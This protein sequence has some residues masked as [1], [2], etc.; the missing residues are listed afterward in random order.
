[1]YVI[2]T[3]DI[4]NDK[5]R[6]K[7]AKNLLQFGIRTQKSVFECEVNKKELVIIKKIASK[8]SDD[9]DLVTL[10]EIYENDTKRIGDVK[11]LEVDDLVF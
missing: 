10:Y 9:N 6:M 3:Y 7:L 8:F 4:R 11:Y 5:K 1:M 2:V